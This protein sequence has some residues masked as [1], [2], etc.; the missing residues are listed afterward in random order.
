MLDRTST[1]RWGESYFFMLSLMN[2]RA[3]LSLVWAVGSTAI[4]PLDPPNRIWMAQG[5]CIWLRWW[6]ICNEAL[7]QCDTCMPD[8]HQWSKVAQQSKCENHNWTDDV[9]QNNTAL[10]TVT[11]DLPIIS[12]EIEE[13]GSSPATPS[14]IILF[15]RAKGQK[16][17]KFLRVKAGAKHVAL[18]KRRLSDAQGI[19]TSKRNKHHLLAVLVAKLDWQDGSGQIQKTMALIALSRVTKYRNF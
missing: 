13:Y 16:S 10:R 12:S 6:D 7:R 18:I 17:I 11:C 2:S 3:L 4:T 5:M 14:Y 15:Q 19:N 9:G 8:S 1:V